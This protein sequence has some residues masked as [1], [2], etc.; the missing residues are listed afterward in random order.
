MTNQDGG[1]PTIDLC[2]SP[3]RLPSNI[4]PK[5]SSQALHQR[6]N[7]HNALLH[8][9]SLLAPSQPAKP[10]SINSLR[11]L[12]MRILLYVGTVDLCILLLRLEHRSLPY[13]DRQT[14]RNGDRG[15]VDTQFFMWI[16][17]AAHA[18]I[19]V[20]STDAMRCLTE[21]RPACIQYRSA[22][23]LRHVKNI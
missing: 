13:M 12:P 8:K 18:S 23:S 9:L 14:H 20:L 22:K 2:Q 1:Y 3:M 15:G 19:S 4:T 6:L 7:C 11:C 10:I 16:C 5:L 21:L 17:R